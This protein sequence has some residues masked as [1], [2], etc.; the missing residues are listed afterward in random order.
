[1]DYRDTWLWQR[2]FVQSRQDATQSEQ[3][4]FQERYFSM[5]E[6]A[7]ALVGRI[8]ADMPTMTVHDVSHLDSLWE[9]GSILAREKVDLNPPEAF[10]FGGAIL[11]HD[12]AMT[13]AAYPNGLAGLKETLAWKDSYARISMTAQEASGDSPSDQL[14]EELATADA[15]RI[16][17]APQAE[18]LPSMSWKSSVGTDEFLIDDPEIRNF[19]GP[20]IGQLAHSHWWPIARVED[21]L[22]ND[23]GPLGGRT[24]NR[25]DLTKIACLLRTSDAMHIDRRRAPAFLRKLLNPQGVSS[26]HWAFQERMAVPFVD[27]EA[28]VYTAA[29]PFD[30]SLAEAWW[31]AY[32]ALVQVD[33]ELRSVDHLLQKRSTGR[34]NANR[35]RGIDGPRELAKFV[36]T[37]G[38]VPVDSTVRVS[39]V[40][41]IVSTLG[42]RKLYGNEPAAALRELIQNASDAVAVRRKLQQRSQTWGQ[43]TIGLEKR[44]HETWL[45]V[46]D[47]GVGMSP[48]VLTGPLIDFGNS[49]WRSP[50]AAQE[51]PGIQASGL[52]VRGKFGIGFFSIFML[53]K[54]VSVTSRRYDKASDSA[55]TLEFQHGLASRPV[56]YETD[57]QDYPIDGGTRVSVCLD[58]DPT[59]TG[60]L[61]HPS[62]YGEATPLLYLAASIAPNLDVDLVVKEGDSEEC[63]V[64][65]RDWLTLAESRFFARLSAAA[66]KDKDARA[67]DHSRLRI[68]TRDGQIYGRAMI[69]TARFG[70]GGRGCITVGGLRAR[71]IGYISGLL[72]GREITAARND[73]LA[74]VP[75]D[76]LSM[77]ATE[78]AD[79]ISQTLIGDE[80]KARGA[81]TILACGGSIGDL[82]IARLNGDWLSTSELIEFLSS[83]EQLD[84][85]FGSVD[86][87]AD[88]EVHPKEF[89][90]SF[91]EDSQIL[92]VPNEYAGYGPINLLE[93]FS[94]ATKTELPSNL[95]EFVRSVIENAWAPW[96][97]DENVVVGSVNG[98]EIFR[99]VIRFEKDAESAA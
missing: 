80:G 11:L 95:E 8:Q 68:L 12:A 50:L 37:I 55:R 87:D 49:F 22:A 78:Q 62:K 52:T 53:G 15:L 13:V 98:S 32:D 89:E 19:Y 24:G 91:E 57:P 63:V 10:V 54:K 40:P 17:H 5:R 64:R 48:N 67:D 3:Q 31:L 72:A 75:L 99:E 33:K 36:E 47:T 92:F 86:Y 9:M 28:L 26:Q 38:W 97:S 23:L 74:L 44:D 56:L 84:V 4:Y 39:D 1:M 35:V 96:R 41:K 58:K 27:E 42:G 93:F 45:V 77:W 20:K 6:K 82:P 34:L 60:G 21:D 59:L 7:A 73:A 90:S 18:K 76:V 94:E 88:L 79:L 83:R 81:Q 65:P 51:F 30:L 70:S 2:A 16:M 61:L 25:I 69:E 66:L 46:E 14:I 29:P 71:N 43:V 85:Y